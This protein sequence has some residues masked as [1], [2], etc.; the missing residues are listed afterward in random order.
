MGSRLFGTLTIT[1][2]VL[3][4]TVPSATGSAQDGGG[5]AFPEVVDVRL[6]SGPNPLDPT[7]GDPDGSPIMDSEVEVHLAVDPNDPDHLLASWQQDRYRSGGGARSNVVAVSRDGGATWETPI[8]VSGIS[9]C[10][11]ESSPYDRATDPWGA[12]GPDGTAFLSTLAF[13]NDTEV[14]PDD[15]VFVSTSPDG[16][17][18]WHSGPSTLEAGEHF[19]EKPVITAHPAR[20]G[21]LYAVWAREEEEP[22]T[23]Q[24]IDDQMRFA[25]SRD[26]GRTWTSAV[27][28]PPDDPVQWEWPNDI[29]VIPQHDGGTRLVVVFMVWDKLHRE[30]GTP[31]THRLFSISS[32]DSDDSGASWSAPSPIAT[33]AKSAFRG[34]RDEV[35]SFA[36]TN[37]DVAVA[38]DGTMYVA[39]SQDTPVGAAP[40]G[41]EIRIA[42]S[43]DQGATWT[44]PTTVASIAN[45][46][47]L[48]AIAVAGDGTVGVSWYDVRRDVPGDEELTTDVWFAASSDRGVSWREIHLAGPFDLR[49]APRDRDG[50]RYFLGDYAGL[51]GFPYGFGALFSVAPPVAEHGPADVAFAPIS[52]PHAGTVKITGSGAVP[53]EDPGGTATFDLSVQSDGEGALKGH[54]AFDDPS[55]EVRIEATALTSVVLQRTADGMRC[56][57]RGQARVTRDGAVTTEPF[58]LWCLDGG[59]GPRGDDLR[60]DAQSYAGGGA[61]DDGNVTVHG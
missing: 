32:D 40:G 38:P 31:G 37:P 23:E 45:V 22:L 2:T 41:T 30:R 57:V 52:L 14:D 46:A 42:R 13:T 16:G 5:S 33:Y 9:N 4:A 24:V 7:C 28:I 21:R 39:W 25:M 12:I 17:A 6:I 27:T 44:A 47:V 34:D 35:V 51:V 8:T 11:D 58:T 10:T 1:A 61:L 15:A 55:A 18:T 26:G 59:T 60:L 56:T 3:L 20:S 49:R 50:S 29:A 54:V 19:L 53:G 48:P 43:D 36:D